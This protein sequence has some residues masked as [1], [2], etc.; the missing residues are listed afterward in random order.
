MTLYV[1]FIQIAQVYPLPSFLS[2]FLRPNN[3][4]LSNIEKL[5]TTKT[6]YKMATLTVFFMELSYWA[7]DVFCW[8]KYIVKRV[9]L[10]LIPGNIL[11][12]V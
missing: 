12:G 8:L 7:F 6:L 9:W 2:P 4:I 5:T 1:I 11:N 10:S 3:A